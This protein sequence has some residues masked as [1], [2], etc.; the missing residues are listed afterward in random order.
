M[1]SLMKHLIVSLAISLIC[2]KAQGNVLYSQQVVSHN[3]GGF[4]SISQFSHT[5]DNFTATDDWHLQSVTFAG[6]WSLD[7]RIIGS[8]DTSR[9]FR[10][11][12]FHDVNGQPASS[13]FRR[14]SALASLTNSRTTSTPYDT[15]RAY[16]VRFD[17]QTIIP[18][19]DVEILEPVLLTSGSRYWM[20]V[21]DES[22]RTN[23][24][25]GFYWTQ[26]YGGDN[27]IAQRFRVNFPWIIH[28][29]YSDT[30]F[31]LHGRVIP[32]PPTFL[33]T[34]AALL[35]LNLRRNSR[36]TQKVDK[37]SVV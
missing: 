14:I 23:L 28:S 27:R 3:T 22:N 25:G 33:L 15:Y 1:V 5:A 16:D 35:L 30:N 36:K 19:R 20:A 11:E 29:G 37:R 12:I 8:N 2:V 31:T 4:T 10:L 13:P 32:E 9:R 6:T 7:T 34:T 18:G 24:D 26:S 17:I 21:I